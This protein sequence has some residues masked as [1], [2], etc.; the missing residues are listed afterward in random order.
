[1]SVDPELDAPLLTTLMEE[2]VYSGWN[3]FDLHSADTVLRDMLKLV[4]I[5]CT[6]P[7]T[8]EVT[9]S[10]T[11]YAAIP[12]YCSRFTYKAEEI[13]SYEAIYQYTLRLP[14]VPRYMSPVHNYGDT[15]YLMTTPY[16]RRLP[17]QLTEPKLNGSVAVPQS[18]LGI[19]ANTKYSVQAAALLEAA[20]YALLTAFDKCEKFYVPD[21]DAI[22]RLSDAL[23]EVG[24]EYFAGRIDVGEAVKQSLQIVEEQ[25]R[26][27]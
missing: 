16:T 6:D 10:E 9:L 26:S 25:N 17:L 27:K 7:K 4:L 2:A 19:V 20:V 8:G 13:L 21:E 15:L 11:D 5:S 24:A 23:G 1:M 22:L 3:A 18:F 14:V 12:E